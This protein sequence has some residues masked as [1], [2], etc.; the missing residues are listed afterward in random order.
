[1]SRPL[2]L[3]IGMMWLDNSSGKRD[4]IK[5]IGDASMY[6]LGKHGAQP[7]LCHVHPDMFEEDIEAIETTFTNGLKAEVLIIPDPTIL[8]YHIWIGVLR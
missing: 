8:K 3:R 7:Q 6:F 1:M 5:V 4:P 2:T